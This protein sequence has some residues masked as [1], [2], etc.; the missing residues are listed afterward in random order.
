MMPVY[1][2]KRMVDVGTDL[3]KWEYEYTETTTLDPPPSDGKKAPW[4]R[5]YSFGVG[6]VSGAGSSPSRGSVRYR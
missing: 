1:Q 6:S 4:K 3:A 2:W 5:V